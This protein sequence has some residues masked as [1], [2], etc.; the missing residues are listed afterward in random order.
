MGSAQTGN[1]SVQ[2][3]NAACVWFIDQLENQNLLGRLITLGT[4]NIGGLI[5]LGSLIKPWFGVTVGLVS[6]ETESGYHAVLQDSMVTPYFKLL[7]VAL[8]AYLV[9][10][11]FRCRQQAPENWVREWAVAGARASLFGAIAVFMYPWAVVTHDVQLASHGAWIH[12]QHYNVTLSL[13][14]I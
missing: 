7:V 1:G 6:D 11:L 10:M 8:L 3:I 14:H 9:G 4:C 5:L 12:D 13:I 2:R